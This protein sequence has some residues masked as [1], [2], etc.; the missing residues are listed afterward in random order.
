M[1][2]RSCP[3][4][5]VAAVLLLLTACGETTESTP[6][7]WELAGHA[8][9]QAYRDQQMEQAE[10][11]FREALRLAS[12]AGSSTGRMHAL[13]GLAASHAATGKLAIADSLYC[14]LLDLQQQRLEADSLSGM[15]V[16]RTLGSLGEINLSRGEIDGAE[17]YFSRIM[18]LDR[19][20]LVDLRPEE[21]ALAYALHGRGKVLAARGRAAAADS[22][23]S[24]A[25]GLRLFAQGFSLYIGDDMVRAE[26]AWRRALA[27]Q[28][29]G[30]GAEHEDV[31]RTAHALGQLLEL[32]GRRQ[33]AIDQ[34]HR[35]ARVY[36]TTAA[37]PIDEAR[38][39]DDL[40]L[41]LQTQELGRS[42]SLRSR[43]SRLR[44]DLDS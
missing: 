6:E 40:A 23:R 39:L 18:E 42:D 11:G 28:E 12:A 41:L 37:S 32:L 4:T 16:V 10:A 31:A 36:A 38:V 33:D 20:G 1:D 21:P 13:E 22:L 35:A 3:G 26:Q 27:H 14:I 30:L 25:Q 17:G 43:A 2:D 34:Y 9:E 24:R 5:R 15:V 19:S 44:Q 8:A 29:E 7:P